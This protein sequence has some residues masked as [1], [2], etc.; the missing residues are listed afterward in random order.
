MDWR[1]S[2]DEP[3]DA[4]SKRFH[5]ALDSEEGWSFLRDEVSDNVWMSRWSIDGVDESQWV[6]VIRLHDLGA[7]VD[8]EMN[9][10]H[11]QVH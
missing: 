3:L 7:Q 2:S 9:V 4:L 10:S 5:E 6:A 1:F 8:L 11:L